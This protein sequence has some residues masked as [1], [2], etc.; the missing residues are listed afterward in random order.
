MA[1]PFWRGSVCQRQTPYY[2]GRLPPGRIRRAGRGADALG[3]TRPLSPKGLK[4]LPYVWHG[5]RE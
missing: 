1:T 4:G 2:T 5:V 3:S